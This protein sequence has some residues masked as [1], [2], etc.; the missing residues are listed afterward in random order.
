MAII[1][2]VGMG[3]AAFLVAAVFDYVSVSDQKRS[4]QS[5][6]DH[7]ALASAHE[8][9]VSTAGDERVQSVATS[10]VKANYKHEHATTAQLL[11]GGDAVKVSIVAAARTFFPGP[12]AN[13][14]EL[15]VSATA[16]V[17]GGG[18]VCMIGLD[19]E[20]VATLNMMNSARLTAKDCAVYSNS[21]STKSLWLHDRARV[22]A[23]LI[24][25]AGGFQGQEES[26]LL[27]KPVEDCA[28]LKDPLRQR[29]NPDVGNLDHCDYT[30]MIVPAGKEA[31]FT[32][33]VY[34]GG[35]NIMG[36]EVTLEPGV[37]TMKNGQLQ[38]G[39]GGVLKGDNVGFFLV[40]K[41]STILFGRASEISLT[42]PR[43]G[44]MAGLLFFEDRDTEFDT[45]HRITSR[46]ARRLVG[47]MYLPKSKLLIDADNPVADQSDYTVIIAR[48][49]ELREGP[50][51]VLNTDYASSTIPVPEGVGN[52]I[53]KKI[54]LI[55]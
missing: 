40:G 30:H 8:L 20:S 15:T 53:H 49:F 5:I 28:P 27:A 38:V 51:L 35:I 25:I 43:T 31:T 44:D 37:Y 16:E 21:V 12:M 18:Y 11:D 6:A 29:P 55:D 34:C 10:F 9:I 22:S 46:D 52:N 3:V 42:A 26:F 48:E 17:S 33:G 54:R 7:A 4:L 13:V 39:G 1:M 50:E 14:K 41:S 24:C 23:D 45:Y 32:P 36:G 47:T 19:A 2:S